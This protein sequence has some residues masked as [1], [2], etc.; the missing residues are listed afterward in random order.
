MNQGHRGKGEIS[1]GPCPP[2]EFSGRFDERKT[3]SKVL[4]GAKDHGLVVM[5]SG[6]RG[7]GKSSYLNWAEYEIQNGTSGLECPAIKKEFLETAGMVF[8]TYRDLLTDLKGHQKFGWFRRSLAD[9]KV[10]TSIDMALGVLE[11][12]SSLAGPYGVGI[13]AGV[14]VARGI[15]PGESVDYTNL[16]SSF[17]QIFRSLSDELIEKGRVLAILLDDAQWSSGPDFQLMKDLIRN[18]P[19]GIVLIIAFRLETESEKRYAELQ[20]EIY[21]FG[22]AEIPL[23]GMAKEGIKEFA[24]QRYDLS[25]DDP[26]ADFLSLNIGDPLCLVSCFNLL[27]K[28]DLAP[29]IDSFQEIVPQA[30]DS[31]RC[32]YTGLDP[33]WQDR[34]NSLCI[35]HPP[36]HLS[37]ISCMLKEQD[38]VRLKD[39]LD[40]SLVFKR[41]EMELYDFAHPSLREYRRKELPEVVRVGLHSQAARCLENLGVRP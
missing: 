5:V 4:Q 8:T 23:G 15:L 34:V 1:L 12:T 9:S 25:I 39:E 36:L 20:D 41:L 26:T 29:D 32:I 31:A 13:N 19:P 22:H 10:R 16:L 18:L 7:S 28:R 37:L 24:A 40:R 3:L 35:L 30:L 6:R 33:R 27:Q 11:K 21:R 14:T 38:M 17:L 2:K